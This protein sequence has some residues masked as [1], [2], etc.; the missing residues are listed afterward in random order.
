MADAFAG[1]TLLPVPGANLIRQFGGPHCA[2]MQLPRGSL[3]EL[4]G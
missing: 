2:T 4:A 1:K 3:R